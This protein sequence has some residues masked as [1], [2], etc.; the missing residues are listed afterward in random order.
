MAVDNCSQFKTDHQPSSTREKSGRRDLKQ[1]VR[2]GMGAPSGCMQ[3]EDQWSSARAAEPTLER[4]KS[5][6]TCEECIIISR[7]ICHACY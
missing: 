6:E 1:P 4:K 3:E 2:A 7:P 5:T